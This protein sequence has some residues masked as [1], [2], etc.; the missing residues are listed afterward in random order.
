MEIG[1]LYQFALLV[2]LVSMVVGAGVLALDKFA[3]STGVTTA[4]QT[5]INAGRT[6]VGGISTTWLGLIVTI[7]ILSIIIVLIVRGFGARR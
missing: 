2:V 4:A 5:A 7:A 3:T 1:E 6:E